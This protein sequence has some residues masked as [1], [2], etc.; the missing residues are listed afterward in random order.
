MS[1]SV[2]YLKTT[3]ED[4]GSTQLVMGFRPQELTQLDTQVAHT[5]RDLRLQTLGE[6]PHLRGGG[7]VPAQCLISGD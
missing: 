1:G 5:N 6:Q 2:F 7:T 3:Q 4:P